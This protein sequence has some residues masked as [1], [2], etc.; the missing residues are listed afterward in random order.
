VPEIS[1]FICDFLNAEKGAF[2]RYEK[3]THKD[4]SESHNKPENVANFRDFMLF[5]GNLVSF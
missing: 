5:A 3:G 4:E 1:V 2:C